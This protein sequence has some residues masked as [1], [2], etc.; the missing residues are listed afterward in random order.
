MS[1]LG[2]ED[3]AADSN[4]PGHP[5]AAGTPSAEP[6]DPTDQMWAAALSDAVNPDSEAVG[7]GPTPAP[8]TDEPV[9]ADP[10]VPEPGA[11]ITTP[12]TSANTAPPVDLPW[13]FIGSDVDDQPPRWRK[14]AII[15]AA[16]GAVAAV[17]AGTQ[18]I[19]AGADEPTTT[20]TTSQ[21]PG[22]AVAPPPPGAPT[23]TAMKGWNLAWSDEFD[24]PTLDETKWTPDNS[25]FGDANGEEQCYTPEN[26]MLEGGN[27][28]LEARREETICPD[29]SVNEF[30]S[31]L[32]RTRDKFATAFGR[33]E[34]RAKLPAGQGFW[35][36]FWLL[37]NDYPYGR[38]GKSGEIDI[39]EAIGSE[40]QKMVATAHWTYDK[41]GWACSRLGEEYVLPG[42]STTDDFHV[43]ALEWTPRH[44]QWEV[45][46][47][48]VYAMGDGER[49]QWSASAERAAPGSLAFPAP[50]DE[51]N[52]MYMIVNLA[53]G[54]VLSGEVDDTTPFPARYE[55]DYVRVFKQG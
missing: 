44:I 7:A 32:L 26:V 51:T 42:S 13:D 2:H 27:L 28:V 8:V 14:L 34:M 3:E 33:F 31:G 38:E 48:V 22:I 10:A 35:P 11:P 30:S 54:G 18:W 20:T 40:P 29:G 47:Q 16:V 9:A 37:S 49:R 12:T 6:L 50:F 19:S 55:I 52:P 36:A 24:R 43:Y 53:V 45:D 4:D 41:C 5:P 25:T 46:G 1:T 39:M 15:A 17:F 21:T 23:T